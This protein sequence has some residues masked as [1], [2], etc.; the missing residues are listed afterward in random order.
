MPVQVT[1]YFQATYQSPDDMQANASITRIKS[2]LP[3]S[4]TDVKVPGLNSG[5]IANSVKIEK[6]DAIKKPL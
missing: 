3:H 1:I 4:I 6:L 5:V 2:V